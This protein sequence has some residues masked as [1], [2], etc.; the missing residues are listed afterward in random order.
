MAT[1]TL[2]WQPPPALSDGTPLSGEIRYIVLRGT[3]GGGLSPI[4]PSPVATTSFTDTG[5]Q[6]DTPYRYAVRAVRTD[7]GATATGAESAVVVA[8]PAI[9]TPPNPPEN[10]VAVPSAGAV[11]LAWNPSRGRPVALY[12]VYRA[13]E[14]G[15]FERIG[16]TAPERTTYTDRDVQRGVT[17]RYAVTAT[18][19][20]RQ[21]NESPRSNEVT[22]TVPQ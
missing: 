15:A 10:L 22:V 21:P 1:V 11:G 6:N 5:L 7:G 18:D 9:T 20:A 8:T 2:T 17:Y 3:G 13:S 4:T 14:G 16:T 19:D 12:S